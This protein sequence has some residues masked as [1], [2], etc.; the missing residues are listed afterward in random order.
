MTFYPVIIPTLS[1]YT[2]LRRCVESLARNTYA[3]QTELIIGLDYPP[4]EKYVEG[5]QQVRAYLPTITGFKKVTIFERTENWGAVR[6]YTDLINY[7]CNTYDA[8]IATEDDNEFSPCFLDYMNLMLQHYKDD[9][10]ISTVS[11]YLP[12]ELATGQCLMANDQSIL[13]SYDSNAWGFG[14]WRDR[15]TLDQWLVN[16]YDVL[17]SYKKSWKSFIT[18]PA[19]FRM[20]IKMAS[21]RQVWADVIRTQWNIV[22]GTFQIRPAQSL[23]RNW[24]NDGTGINCTID[25]SIAQQPISC[26][27][28]FQSPTSWVPQYSDTVARATFHMTWPKNPLLFVGK[29]IIT[30]FL[31]LKYRISRDGSHNP[32]LNS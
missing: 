21:E 29:L 31:Y 22:N 5:Y 32:L 4:S 19:C 18:Y 15:G 14:T 17:H 16:A 2:H 11:A 3:S 28:T 1:R 9:R 30:V 26:A 24:G 6:N 27:Q 13:F 7:V 23:A 10:R 8:F 12:Q 25:E 20:L